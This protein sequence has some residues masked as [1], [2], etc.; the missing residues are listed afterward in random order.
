MNT[1]VGE[2]YSEVVQGFKELHKGKRV[3][4]KCITT[5]DIR[6]FERPQP[7]HWNT[8]MVVKQGFSVF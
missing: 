3:N 4:I 7:V 5:E 1:S 8:E 2:K 6:Y